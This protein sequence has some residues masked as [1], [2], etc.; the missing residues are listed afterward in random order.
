M[1][2]SLPKLI[3]VNWST[4]CYQAKRIAFTIVVTAVVQAQSGTP[5]AITSVSVI[6]METPETFRHQTV[7]V[8]DGVIAAMGETG[9]VLVPPGSVVINGTGMYLLP[10]LTDMHVHFQFN[11]GVNGD[12]CKLFL[13][14]GVTTVVNLYGTP[15]HL[16]LRNEAA[17]GTIPCPRVFT[18][19][20]SLGEPHG[21]E[22]TSTPQQ[23]EEEV[24][25]QKR[26][27]YDFVKL[28]GDFAE[29]TYRH[30]LAVARREHVRVIGHAPRNLGAAPMLGERQDA[31]A[32]LEEYLYAYFF[33]RQKGPW[34]KLA[35]DV[36]QQRIRSLAA[37]TAK[38]GTAVITT[39][40]V[41]KGISEQIN[42][43]EAVVHR[44]EVRM[45]PHSVQVSWHW[46]P[47]DNTY[48]RRFRRDDLPSFH[49]SYELLQQTALAMQRAGVPL[50]A[51]TDTPTAVVVPGFS[52]QAELQE[53]VTA[54][55]SPYEA[56]RAATINA[57]KFLQIE[58]QSGTIAVGKR[59]DL[60][61]LGGNPLK[62]VGQ[63][64]N[65]RAVIANGHLLTR[66]RLDAML[67]DVRR[68]APSH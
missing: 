57:A 35:N 16:R 40:A 34:K 68:R 8:R 30:L 33:F 47:P 20:P 50:L 52:M 7:I 45:V 2:A 24:M 31:V 15:D 28:H 44:P 55:P 32:H 62:S 60:V 12:F 65:I 48:V 25:S 61:L 3:R 10:G 19:G 22:P 58:E 59:A 26:A 39:L 4:L 53:I 21:Q 23:V 5:I 49:S 46:L 63:L 18:S 13:A 17:R 1:R 67:R 66:A 6:P 56:L 29:E 42:D 9:Q 43:V 41:Y 11:E 38:A 51:G 54:G 14:S 64:S 36:A 37:A 27:G